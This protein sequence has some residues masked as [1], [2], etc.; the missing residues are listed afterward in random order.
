MELKVKNSE[1][2]RDSQWEEALPYLGLVEQGKTW[3]YQGQSLS[4]GS[5]TVWQEQ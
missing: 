2:P 5:V 1:V 3:R 4:L